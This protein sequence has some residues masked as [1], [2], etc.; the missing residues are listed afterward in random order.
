MPPADIPN[1]D[2]KDELLLSRK[3]GFDE[4]LKGFRLRFEADEAQ[5]E[6]LRQAFGMFALTSLITDIETQ[7]KPFQ[8]NWLSLSVKLKA[9]VE[10]ECGVSL[11]PFSH[12]ISADFTLDCVMRA[13]APPPFMATERELKLDELDEPDIIEDGFID[14]GLY[15]VEALGQAYDPFARK[16]GIVFEE[17]PKE[18]EPSPFSILA[19]LKDQDMT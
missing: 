6:R 9:Y 10:Q 7:A 13:D 11:E 4:A 15:I 1:T 17:P 3:I 19:K 18:I 12:V 5:R 14:L 8:K 2:T 16:P